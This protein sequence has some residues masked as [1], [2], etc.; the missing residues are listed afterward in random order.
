MELRGNK[1]LYA[2]AIIVGLCV[3]GAAWLYFQANTADASKTEDMVLLTVPKK[4][5]S[6]YDKIEADDLK[7]LEFPKGSVSADAVSTPDT[8]IGKYTIEPLA[9]DKQISRRILVE[10]ANALKD[11]YIVSVNI[12]TIRSADVIEGDTVDV[13]WVT[14]NEANWATG[15]L[16]NSKMIARNARVVNASGIKEA[17]SDSASKAHTGYVQLAITP[18]E[19]PAMV[20]G[21]LPKDDHMVLVKKPSG[22]DEKVVPN[23]AMEQGATEPSSDNE[24]EK[25]EENAPAGEV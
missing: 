23:T 16:N 2:I 5:I 8:I 25:T 15:K 4:D 19:A 11:R 3:A 22:P 18:T 21:S 14:R 10:D 1:K 20:S 7:T 12:D 24:S 9:K 13:Y 6:M 17:S